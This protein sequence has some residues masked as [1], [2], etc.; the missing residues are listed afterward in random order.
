MN[1]Q[2]IDQN[3]LNEIT[4]DSEGKSFFSQSALARLCGVSRSNIIRNNLLCAKGIEMTQVHDSG[5]K[6]AVCYDDIQAAKV[7]QY[8]AL[9]SKAANDTA[10][11]TFMAFAAI[12]IRTW[13]QDIKGWGKQAAIP[14]FNNPVEAA[15]AWADSVEKE[16][17][18]SKQIE[19]VM[20]VL[21]LMTESE[22]CKTWNVAAKELGF[23]PNKLTKKL[24]EMGV[25]M[26]NKPNK[27]V[28]MQRFINANYFEVKTSTYTDH[29]GI[30]HLS[31]TV[32]VTAK[33]M[34]YLA[35]RLK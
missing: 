8:Y 19:E 18:L 25:L 7:I 21:E 2:T 16:Q 15:R 9:E 5:S 17:L 11:K 10:K 1:I 14:D 12:G 13:A 23:G 6:T 32:Y 20:P 33:G 30:E 4:F 3:I 26:A 29:W 34:V 31:H 27:N 22:G 24:R 28:P 35:K